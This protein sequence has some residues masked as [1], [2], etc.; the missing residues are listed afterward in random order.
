[1]RTRFILTALAA[2][3]AVLSGCRNTEQEA[4]V[5][6]MKTV[7][8]RAETDAETRTAFA[9][10]EN[11]IYQTLWTQNDRE[12]LLSLNYGEARSTEIFASDDGKTATFDASFDAAAASA[13]YTFYAVSPAS[14]ARAISPSRRAWSVYIAANQTPSALSVDEAAQLIVAKSASSAE[15][16]DETELRFSH[17]TAYGRISLKNVEIGDAVAKRVELVFSTPVVGQWYWGEDGTLVSNGASHTIT[18]NTDASGD[19]WFACAPVDVGGA[20][21]S[22]SLF[23]D[24]GVL[25]KTIVFPAGRSFSSGKVSR[26]SVDM[27]DA[28]SIL[29]DDSFTRVTD[30]SELV[31]GGEYLIVNDAET[32]ALGAQNNE[33]TKHRDQVAILVENGKV[34][35]PGTSTILIL[36]SGSSSGTWSFQTGSGY[37]SAAESKNILQESAEKNNYSSWTVTVSEG[38]TT[39]QAK[40]GQ[41]S[42]IKYNGLATRFSCYKETASN[43]SDVVLFRRPKSSENPVAVDPLLSFAEYGSYLKEASWTYAPG[44]DQIQRIREADGTVT[45]LLLNPTTFKQLEVKG[46]DPS[47]HKGQKADVSV[48]YRMCS[49]VVLAESYTF[50]V[51]A[52]DGPKVW[53]SDGLGQGIILKK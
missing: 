11:G 20:S 47:L 31:E 5:P 36:E 28:E 53:L 3:V 4:P 29:A 7:R 48:R 10:A 46:F 16:P 45:F 18:L 6:S 27:A 15:L 41:A 22:L 42:L 12:I 38:K 44:S 51:A 21:M 50:V 39:I 1:M 9:K 19:L 13:P 26:F 52:E 14:A 37:L 49:N 8:F 40:A 32:Y 33:G 2:A 17:L 24:Q 35:D 23:T 34:V 43:M 25:R 30:V